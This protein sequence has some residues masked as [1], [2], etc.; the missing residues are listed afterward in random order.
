MIRTEMR[1]FY[2][3]NYLKPSLVVFNLKAK[4]KVQALEELQDVLAG[5]K[6]IKKKKLILTR[7][8]NPALLQA[9]V[10][11]AGQI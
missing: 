1:N 6:L 3:S 2:L 5:Q 10:D 4:D 8:I 11:T 7:I 9:R